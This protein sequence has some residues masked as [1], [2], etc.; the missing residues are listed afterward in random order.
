MKQATI[1]FLWRLF[2][3]LWWFFHNAVAHPLVGALGLLQL[4]RLERRLHAFT[5]PKFDVS[6]NEQALRSFANAHGVDGRYAE[7]PKLT[8]RLSGDRR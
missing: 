5:A 8:H 1:S 2:L 7:H 6:R 4:H 3:E